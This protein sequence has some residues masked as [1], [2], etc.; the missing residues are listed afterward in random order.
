[1]ATTQSQQSSIKGGLIRID[2]ELIAACIYEATT[3]SSPIDSSGTMEESRECIARR[4]LFLL[5]LLELLV[6]GL[7]TAAV[8][9]MV[10]RLLLIPAITKLQQVVLDRTQASARDERK[11]R[12][13]VCR[14]MKQSAI[15]SL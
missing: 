9:M 2:E 4:P 13:A 11:E 5:I 12:S 3:V 15:S 14:V 1:M 7:N 10:Q 6:P 8:S